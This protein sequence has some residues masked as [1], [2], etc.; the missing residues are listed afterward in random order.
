MRL[1]EAP[2][3]LAALFLPCL[4]AAIAETGGSRDA[5]EGEFP[6]IVSVRDEDDHI[7]GGSLIEFEGKT[8]WVLTA[9]HCVGPDFEVVLGSNDRLDPAARRYKV[10]DHLHHPAL[11]GRG[12]RPG[13][14]IGLLELEREADAPGARAV[15]L[16]AE[17]PLPF[18]SG[19]ALLA[20]GWGRTRHDREE[21][22]RRLRAV[23]LPWV[24][25]RDCALSYADDE[26]LP[27]DRF[28]EDQ[29]CA[30]GR[31]AVACKFD[32]GGP[33]VLRVGGRDTLV[34]LLA[35]SDPCTGTRTRPSVFTSVPFHAAWV[36]EGIRA[37]RARA[38][39]R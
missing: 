25:A 15:A 1:R 17:P 36:P 6:Y 7:C 20:A 32:S 29:V 14:D 8:K 39:K 11:K 37:M 33:L 3:L 13:Y 21:L 28:A 2:L 5:R 30:G 18:P 31:G 22:P 38:A 9:A 24:P 27:A 23:E 34:G 26:D 35:W 4:A 19:G 16:A 10:V 12:D